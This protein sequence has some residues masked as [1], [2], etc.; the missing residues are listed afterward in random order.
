MSK[1][2]NHYENLNVSNLASLDDIRASYI[3]LCKLFELDMG[4]IEELTTS[5]NI[6]SNSNSRTVYDLAVI[7]ELRKKA[8]RVE[9]VME[10]LQASPSLPVLNTVVNID[11]ILKQRSIE[12]EA[13]EKEAN[14]FS[15]KI[16]AILAAVAILG[17]I[18][19]GIAT[20]DN[21]SRI[22]M[23]NLSEM[24]STSQY[25]RP[26]VAPNGMAFPEATSY[27]AGYEVQNNQGASSLYVNNLKNDNDV[28]LKLLSVDGD[29][30]VAVRHVLIKG[31]S[32]FNLENLS[33]GKYEIQ[34]MDLVAGLAGKSEVF[35]VNE[36]KTAT[37]STS[38]S[39]SVKLQT[40]VNGVLRV[41]N[42]KVDEFN[43]LASL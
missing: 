34:Y 29:K 39:L 43:S 38:T 1:L 16:A 8:A 5:Y 22:G 15:S 42:V 9:K 27:L 30:P 14:G 3:N 23:L 31:K 19:L 32:D 13:M 35:S 40:T 33:V 17:T 41:E 20:S 12:R 36:T 2:P 10:N 11:E 37:G 4:M 24:F 21:L 25:V 26:S 7:E 28:Y 6:L 18:T